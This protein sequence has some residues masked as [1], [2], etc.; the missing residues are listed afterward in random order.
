MATTSYGQQQAD[1][2]Q[3]GSGSSGGLGAVLG[4]YL[5]D[6][7]GLIDL[8]DQAQKDSLQKTGLM[9]TMLN[10]QLSPAGSVPPVPT[11]MTGFQQKSTGVAYPMQMVAPPMDINNPQFGVP[12]A[13]SPQAARDTPVSQT[14]GN[15]QPVDKGN[16][17]EQ[18]PGTGFVDKLKTFASMF[19]G[20]K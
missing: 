13:V 7:A 19:T 8:K 15:P 5:A 17:W 2:N 6:K 1:W 20:G 9:G 18:Y 10:N 3:Y 4:A 14:G 16:A 12:S 11:D